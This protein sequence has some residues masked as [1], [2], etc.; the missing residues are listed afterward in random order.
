MRSDRVLPGDT[1]ANTGPVSPA[2]ASR[3]SEHPLARP[4][5]QGLN[6]EL[7]AAGQ[8][9]RKSHQAALITAH[10]DVAPDR[11]GVPDAGVVVEV[12]A[13]RQ[14]GLAA[15]ALPHERR[16]KDADGAAAREREQRARVGRA[17][18]GVG[19]AMQ[20]LVLGQGG[21]D[22]RPRGEADDGLEARGQW[23]QDH[24]GA[25]GGRE[26][27]GRGLE[28]DRQQRV[29][30]DSLPH[31]ISRP[32]PFGPRRRAVGPQCGRR[33]NG[34]SPKDGPEA[35]LRLPDVTAS[36]ASPR[37]GSQRSTATSSR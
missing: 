9:G 34:G 30:R 2:S 22:V 36:R 20:R 4:E 17:A 7:A 31:A 29:H 28:Q 11:P 14:H 37:R 24:D 12:V 21:A 6:A 16:V 19:H 13:H 33:R 18:V 15:G 1:A 23:G 32:V 10:D 26:A 25:V 8:A 27:A 5:P 3:T 35:Y